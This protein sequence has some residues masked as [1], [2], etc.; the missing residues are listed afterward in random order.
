[1]PHNRGQSRIN[2]TWTFE[3]KPIYRTGWRFRSVTA[4]IGE[5]P[6]DLE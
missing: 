6:I 3:S 1:M 2:A 5:A 4:T